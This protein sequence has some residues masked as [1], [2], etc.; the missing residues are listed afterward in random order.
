MELNWLNE[1][2]Q[3]LKETK[4]DRERDRERRRLAEA[5]DG[6]DAKNAVKEHWSEKRREDMTER[7]WRIFR[8]DFNISYKGVQVSGSALPIRNWE[9]AALPTTLVKAITELV[10]S[11]L[12]SRILP[13]TKR[14]HRKRLQ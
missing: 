8:E 4:L 5:L 10:S 6:L 1:Y 2:L 14:S 3:G 9:E 13:E 12:G 7:D 11:R